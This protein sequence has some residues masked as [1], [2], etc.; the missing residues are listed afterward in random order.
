MGPKVPV[1][2]FITGMWIDCIITCSAL[3]TI[4]QKQQWVS[5]TKP[6]HKVSSALRQ[7]DD[8]QQQRYVASSLFWLCLCHHSHVPSLSLAVTLLAF[9]IFLDGGPV[10]C[11]SRRPFPFPPM[12]LPFFHFFRRRFPDSW[13]GACGLSL[14]CATVWFCL[15]V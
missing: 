9:L 4:R 15:V 5:L 11:F 3:G 13:F 10:F 6:T 1:P 12:P 7:H 2:L 14:V 8:K